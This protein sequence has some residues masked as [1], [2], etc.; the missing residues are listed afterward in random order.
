MRLVIVLIVFFVFSVPAQAQQL[1][2]LKRCG[3]L[4]EPKTRLSCYEQ[5]VSG[6][7]QIADQCTLFT[8]ESVKLSCFDQLAIDVP[9]PINKQGIWARGEC[10]TATRA[11]FLGSRFAIE[12]RVARNSET[13]IAM[14]AVTWKKNAVVFEKDQS[15]S[16]QLSGMSKCPSMPSQAYFLL[17]ETLS[18][19][20]IVDELEETCVSK[21]GRECAERLFGY[22]DISDDNRLSSAEIGR[23]LRAV[24]FFATYEGFSQNSNSR[25]VPV[26]QLVATSMFAT[27]SGPMITRNLLASYDFDGD[28]FL[29]LNEIFQDREP[30]LELSASSATVSSVGTSSAQAFISQLVALVLSS[31]GQAASSGLGLIFR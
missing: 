8:S 13:Q 28:G 11:I 6:G 3:R 18:L 15:A 14:G 25:Y 27:V 21:G 20:A 2:A 1:D 9:V 23:V 10:A 29:T 24:A 16:M 30:L 7:T 17:G 12:Y 4:G 26:A 22:I 5:V 19:A 31:A